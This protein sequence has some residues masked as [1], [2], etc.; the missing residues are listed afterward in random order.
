MKRILPGL[1]LSII[2]SIISTFIATSEL[3]KN[4]LNLSP[5]ILAIII[6]IISGNIFKIKDDFKPGI[7]F[8]LKKLLR[9]AIILLGFKLTF[10]SIG[11]IGLK[12]LLVDTF[13]VISTFI[14]CIW[15]SRKVFKIDDK[16]SYLLASGCSICG[17]SAVLA[18]SPVVKSENHQNA[19]ALGTITIFGTLSMF[20][21]PLLYKAG[22]M[23]GFNETDYGIFTGATIHEVAQVVAA[24]FSVSDVAGNTAT[25][26]K[27]T[28][29]I[30]LAPMLI[31][32][33]FYLNKKN[34][35]NNAKVEKIDIPWFVIG[36][37]LM[38]G[39]NSLNI[40]PEYIVKTIITFDIYLF[41]ISMGAMGMETNLNKIRGVGMKPVYSSICISLFL[42]IV[43]YMMIALV[44]NF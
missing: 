27:L 15:V 26:T 31:G 9:L 16:L 34:A 30:M 39:L 25:I 32:L 19:V 14:F 40:L 28:R 6:G 44:K 1:G 33:S 10:Q 22:I 20:L 8:S 23:P 11:Q 37:V 21:Y 5:L 12:G 7:T 41:V 24:G 38:V 29:V 2:I 42:F 17:A 43:G 13:M 18:T 3:N 36:F 35:T 4:S